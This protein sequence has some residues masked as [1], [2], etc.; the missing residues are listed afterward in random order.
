MEIVSAAIVLLLVMDPFGNVP[1]VV[2]GLRGIA[3]ARRPYVVLRECAIAYAVLVLFLFG[4]QGLLGLLGLSDTA[5]EIAGGVILFLIALRMV[6]PHPDGIF[7]EHLGDDRGGEPFI[8]PIAVPA[9]AGPS[10]LASVIVLVSRDPA[11]WPHWLAAITIATLVTLAILIA[12]ERISRWMGERGIIAM[13][14]LTGLIL[15]TIA[16][17]MLLTGIAKFVAG[18][19]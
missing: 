14:R 4:G 11:R 19:H 9:I 2:L 7:G 13:E 12:A 8:V 1:L 18:L 6:F 16:I 17:Q 3:P 5:L 10:A 15:T